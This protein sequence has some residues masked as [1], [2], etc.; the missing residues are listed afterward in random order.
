MPVR[1]RCK[2]C[3]Q[4]L[5]IARR[6]MGTEVRCPE[7]RK[8]VVVPAVDAVDADEPTRKG[9]PLFAEA[10]ADPVVDPPKEIGSP[11]MSSGALES[12]DAELY[13]LPDPARGASFVLSPLYASLLTLGAVILLGLAFALGMLFE[14][15]V[16]YRGP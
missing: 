8:M 3:N 7:C 13:R 12:F 4:L 16:L 2:H 9:G 10:F 15:Y 5:G 1:F 11:A 6:K 14:R